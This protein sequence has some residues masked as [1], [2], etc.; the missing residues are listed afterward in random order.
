MHF[1]ARSSSILKKSVYKELLE[2]LKRHL[3]DIFRLLFIVKTTTHCIAPGVYMK[4]E[5][6]RSESGLGNQVM[7]LDHFYGIHS[8]NYPKETNYPKLGSP[9]IPNFRKANNKAPIYGV[10]QPTIEGIRKVVHAL[11]K[12]KERNKKHVIWINLREEPIVYVEGKPFAPRDV[13]FF[14][15]KA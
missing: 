2:E 12:T 8:I 9:D 4:T 1:L 13:T 10:G 5:V 15:L 14:I 11:L 6:Y 3:Y 7:K